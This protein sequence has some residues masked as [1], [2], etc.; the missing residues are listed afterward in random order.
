[1]TLDAPRTPK[2]PAVPAVVTAMIMAAVPEVVV[3]VVAVPDEAVDLDEVA[4]PVDAAARALDE[5]VAERAIPMT[6]VGAVWA[7]ECA[8]IP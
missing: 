5:E 7:V 4:V 1:M 3:L 8:P 6:T 2:G